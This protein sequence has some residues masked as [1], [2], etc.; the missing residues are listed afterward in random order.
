MSLENY[1][2]SKQK[3]SSMKK[4]YLY[5]GPAIPVGS[6]DDK[7]ANVIAAMRAYTK[8]F[9]NKY[10]QSFP[11]K[12][13]LFISYDAERHKFYIGTRSWLALILDNDPDCQMLL[14]SPEDVLCINY[15]EL[16]FISA[17]KDHRRE[18]VM[19]IHSAI[20]AAE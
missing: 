13:Q 16:D 1:V 2:Q 7:T 18:F 20:L 19:V 17:I 3:Q 11:V 6:I 10:G 14:T 4:Y 15:D 8:T 9:V 12:D 5:L